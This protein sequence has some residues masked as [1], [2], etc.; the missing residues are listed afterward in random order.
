[1]ESVLQNSLN[2]FDFLLK[3]VVRAVERLIDGHHLACHLHRHWHAVHLLLEV[4]NKGRLHHV[5]AMVA[6]DL[7]AVMQQERLVARQLVLNGFDRH[8]I[9]CLPNLQRIQ[10]RL[11]LLGY[12]EDILRE[13]RPL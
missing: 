12:I 4:F 3:R 10:G 13:K 8:F 7:L 9:D 1:M 5:D 2:R 11:K 6:L